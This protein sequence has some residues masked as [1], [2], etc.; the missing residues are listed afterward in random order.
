MED[1]RQRASVKED[2]RVAI[3]EPVE[4]NENHRYARTK[5]KASR[6]D[7]GN[8]KLASSYSPGGE[9]KEPARTP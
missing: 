5:D 7:L 4:E 3:D 6:R 1:R 2:D 9:R 8:G